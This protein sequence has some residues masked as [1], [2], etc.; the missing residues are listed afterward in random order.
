MSE[1]ADAE[2]VSFSFIASESLAGIDIFGST[3][4]R[5]EIGSMGLSPRVTL[6]E[7]AAIAAAAAA[8]ISATDRPWLAAATPDNCVA[9]GALAG[10][11]GAAPG[12]DGAVATGAGDS[13]GV[14]AAGDG[15]DPDGV[16]LTG[17]DGGEFVF[18][19]ARRFRE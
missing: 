4:D 12:S 16:V 7:A 18:C 9:F 13:D 1:R 14:E 15:A 10:V 11:A 2:A 17:S 3:F 6:A 8:A 19:D 5:G